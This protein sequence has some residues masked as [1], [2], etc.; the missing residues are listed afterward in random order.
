MRNHFITGI[1]GLGLLSCGHNNLQ[2]EAKVSDLTSEC[3]VNPSHHMLNK[4][5][6]YNLKVAYTIN[7]TVGLA[8]G[9][10]E[11]Y[12][13][14]MH[15]Y[16]Y[17]FADVFV[18][19]NGGK[20]GVAISKDKIIISFVGTISN[21]LIKNFNFKAHEHSR[22]PGK[23]HTGFAETY[24]ELIFK[25]YDAV[26]ENYK[27]QN[28]YIGG[29]SQAGATAVL[30]AWHLQNNGVN[31]TGVYTQGSPKAGDA[32]FAQEY[33]KLLGHRTYRFIYNDDMVARLPPA[34]IAKPSVLKLVPTITKP[35][36]GKM[37]DEGDF[38]HVGKTVKIE[39]NYNI[40]S[41]RPHDE[42]IDDVKFWD[43]QNG[44]FMNLFMSAL[45]NDYQKT[46]HH[47]VHYACG[48]TKNM[49]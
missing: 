16:G 2:S 18:G 41:P 32:T 38:K 14:E 26:T 10:I 5:I 23:V 11:S 40:N 31:I 35:F 37:I 17:S 12:K 36:L 15:R 25:L 49:K 33:N 46:D 24:E 3:W 6:G 1:L 4:D 8:S 13:E 7:E 29:L 20:A 27:G 19:Q 34:K 47:W 30:A 28:V 21:T 44:D 43:N 45:S 42:L 9:D 22:Y 39:Q 48:L